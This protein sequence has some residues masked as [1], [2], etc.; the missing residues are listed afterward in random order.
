[1]KMKKGALKSAP[2]FIFIESFVHK[3]N[4]FNF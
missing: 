3:F 1:M 4:D 2:F